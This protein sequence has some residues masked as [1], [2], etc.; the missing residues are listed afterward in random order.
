MFFGQSAGHEGVIK[1]V[2]INHSGVVDL[3]PKYSLHYEGGHSELPGGQ[4]DKTSH[5]GD[6]PPQR[7]MV[8]A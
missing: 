5:R 2:K 3:W 7:G 1:V 6:C 8:V 4:G